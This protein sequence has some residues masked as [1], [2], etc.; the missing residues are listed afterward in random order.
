MVKSDNLATVLTRH[1][2][3]LTAIILPMVFVSNEYIVA[4]FFEGTLK[5]LFCKTIREILSISSGLKELLLTCKYLI[6]LD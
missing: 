1:S 2:I 6:R 5:S 4:E 3:S